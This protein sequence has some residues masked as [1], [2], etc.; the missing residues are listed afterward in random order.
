[1]TSASGPSR[2]IAALLARGPQIVE[3]MAGRALR[4][5]KPFTPEVRANIDYELVDKSI[6]F[7][8]QVEFDDLVEND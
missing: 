1:M 7:M 4:T 8:R 5:V 6:E 3:A 2:H